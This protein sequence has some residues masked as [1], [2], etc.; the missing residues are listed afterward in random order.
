MAVD[1]DALLIAWCVC[2]LERRNVARQSS[3]RRDTTADLYYLAEV[4]GA[5]VIVPPP[6]LHRFGA[7]IGSHQAKNNSHAGAS[8]GESLER[9][10]APA[11]R[12]AL[13]SKAPTGACDE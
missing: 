9:R 4:D 8:G 1:E 12:L 3:S 10:A 7:N 5:A 6:R 2:M 13:C 11:Q